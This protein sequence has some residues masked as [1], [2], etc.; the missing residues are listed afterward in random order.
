MQNTPTRPLLRTTALLFAA[1][2]AGSAALATPSVVHAA[3][4]KSLGNV[5][6]VALY[7]RD[8]PGQNLDEFRGVLV[9]DEN[10]FQLLAVVNDVSRHCEWRAR[11]H[12][13]RVVQRFGD[14]E[15]IL[16]TRTDAPWPVSDR[17]TVLRAKVHVDLPNK[18]VWSRF[19]AIKD[20]RAPPVDGV[21]R[22]PKL[23]GSYKF[24]WLGE[25]RTE[26]TYQVNADPGGLIP[27]WLAQRTSRKI[28]SGTLS[29]LRKQAK[30]M[31][32]R[33]EAF[34][35]KHDPARQKP[36]PAPPPAAKSP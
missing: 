27:N 16:Y 9:I 30:K 14:R 18:T 13:A 19:H 32:G 17:D 34:R 31:R 22:M 26:V 7:G 21:V 1:F 23:S 8:V 15:K 11:C 4:W 25:G 33:Y 36:A 12:S 2:V 24:V 5:N 6:G 3:P 28:P 35:N 10:L 29:G 20:R